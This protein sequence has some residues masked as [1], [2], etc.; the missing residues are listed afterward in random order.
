MSGATPAFLLRTAEIAAQKLVEQYGLAVAQPIP[1]DAVARAVGVDVRLGGLRGAAAR[2]SVLHGMGMIRVADDGISPAR[3]RFG[4]AH[5]LGHYLL[6]R[7]ELPDAC[8][9][10]DLH[11]WGGRRFEHQANV[12]ASELLLPAAVVRPLCEHDEVL[13]ENVQLLAR[14]FDVSLTAAALR[15]A[16]FSPVPCAVVMSDGLSV[17]WAKPGTAWPWRLREKG[18]PLHQNSLAYRMHQHLIR[19]QEAND[20]VEGPAWVTESE[21]DSLVL[22]EACVRMPV[23]GWSLSLLS[24]EEEPDGEDDDESRLP[25]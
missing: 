21:A 13:M 16:A 9:E 25:P 23:L 2:L 19:S 10:A 18:E 6:H 20:T 14:Q 5:E 4:I 8:R 17:K 24:V 11:L 15:Y 1:V 3:I 22:A 7:D 12:F